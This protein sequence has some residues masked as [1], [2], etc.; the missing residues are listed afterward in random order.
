M[1]FTLINPS[2]QKYLADL[3]L[4]AKQ[5]LQAMGVVH[6]FGGDYCTYTEQDKFF[7]YRR[8]NKT[9]RMASMIWFD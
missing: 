4:I 9:G 5:R 8:E 1:A 7:S 6:V 2:E 3:Y